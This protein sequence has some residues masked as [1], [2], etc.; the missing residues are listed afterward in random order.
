M[1]SPT[2]DT[3]GVRLLRRIELIEGSPVVEV[4]TELTQHGDGSPLPMQIWTVAQM[5]TPDAVALGVGD[6]SGGPGPGVRMVDGDKFNGELHEHPGYT[7]WTP[8]NQ[9][10]GK[11]LGTIG[12]WIAA[13][14]GDAMFLQVAPYDPHGLYPENSS[15]Q[16]YVADNYVELEL[17]SPAAPTPPG[18]TRTHKVVWMLNTLEGAEPLTPDQ[19]WTQRLEAMGRELK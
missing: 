16:L 12:R 15:V 2:S 7:L 19:V 6:V 5:T 9:P 14:Y 8:A 3:L 1:L 17:L 13:R 18:Q 11:K 4:T 10:T